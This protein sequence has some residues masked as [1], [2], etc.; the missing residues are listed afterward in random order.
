MSGESEAAENDA[1]RTS[2][3]FSKVDSF[4]DVGSDE[5]K[6]QTKE[7]L[8]KMYKDVSTDGIFAGPAPN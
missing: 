6:V 8:L 7:I 2:D 4:L 1:T 3:E 5:D